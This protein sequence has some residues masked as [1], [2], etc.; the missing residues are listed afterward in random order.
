[1]ADEP[2]DPAMMVIGRNKGGRPRLGPEPRSTLST[3]IP[4]SL[5]DEIVRRAHD[6][7]KTVSQFVA[8]RL[9]S[10]LLKT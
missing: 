10:S 2:N 7:E 3:W 4:T 8:E 1:M 6:S 5:H 9:A